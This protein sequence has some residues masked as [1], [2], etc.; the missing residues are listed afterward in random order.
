MASSCRRAS[1]RRHVSC[2]SAQ[3]GPR[4][5]HR[6]EALLAATSVALGASLAKPS[7]AAECP[8]LIT[9]PNGAG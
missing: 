1:T 2:M 5:V 9:A 4:P 7:Q 3:E 6:R 8:E